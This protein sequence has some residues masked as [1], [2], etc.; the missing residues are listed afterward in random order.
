M[1]NL[2]KQLALNHAVVSE[3]LAHDHAWHKLKTLQLPSEEA[4]RGFGIPPWLNE[5]IEK[6]AVLIHGAPKIM[7]HTLDPD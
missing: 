7:L 2:W 4:L 1:F 5:D 3:L 6:H